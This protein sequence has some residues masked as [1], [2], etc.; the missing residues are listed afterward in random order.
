MLESAAMDR[1]TRRTVIDISEH[2]PTLNFE[3]AE[4]SQPFTFPQYQRELLFARLMA[5]CVDIAIVSAVYLI[6]VLVTFLEMTQPALDKRYVGVYI[7]GLL[8]LVGVYFLLFMLSSSQTPGMK[9]KHLTVVTRDGFPLDP[10][11]AFMRGLGYFISI[12]PLMLGF[13]W[14]LIDPEHLTW[15]DKVSGTFLKK[16]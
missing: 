6:F 16:T 9:L 3:E 13:V 15:A 7:A 4:L 12:A 14:A 1:K 5:D 10:A 11:T 8:V 2:Q